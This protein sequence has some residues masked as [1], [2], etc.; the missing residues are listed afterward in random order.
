MSVLLAGCLLG[1]NYHRPAI[2]APAVYRGASAAVT[3]KAAASLGN[4]HWVRLYQD[5]VLQE[6]IRTAL[7][8]NYN[9]RIAATRV[10]AA[11]EQAGITRAGEFP[12]AAIDAGGTALRNPKT[13][14]A[15]PSYSTRFGRLNLDVLWNLDF[16][17]KYR[18]ATES[19]RDQWLATQWGQRAVTSSVV[20]QV[21]A[22]YFQLRQLDAAL[23]IAHKT[24][25]ARHDSLHLIQVLDR[26]GS[27]S[28]LDVSQAQEAL[29]QASETVPDLERQIAQQENLIRTLM[30]ENPGPIPRGA[31]LT[32]QPNPPAVP[33]GLPSALI[34]RR[35]DIRQAE[36]Q[37]AA[38]TAGIGVAK[39]ALFPNISLTASGGVESYALNQLFSP[40]GKQ[41][42]VAADLLQPVFAAGSLRA[43]VR[44]SKDQEQAMLLS[45]EQTIQQAFAQV[46]DALVALQKDHAFTQQQQSLTTAAEKAEQLSNVLYQHG[47]GSF[48]QVLVAE[49]NSF[50]AQLNLSQAELNERLALVTLYNALGGGWQQ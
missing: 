46:S 5:P 39:A 19:A 16:W 27:A 1:P 43:G 29:A 35:P 42:N 24:V 33:A 47:G 26:Y 10:L 7:A 31:P 9:I 8:N 18:R 30:G 49:T 21:A 38:A 17:G 6:L 40:A 13:A 50:N 4:Q 36:M 20:A 25:A 32:A 12:T 41:W 45:Y 14:K 11:Q 44:L 37:L 28:E 23:A 3:P 2:A 48:L 22:A 15:L 34:E